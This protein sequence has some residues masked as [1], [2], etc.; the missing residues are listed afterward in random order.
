MEEGFRDTYHLTKCSR[1]A[2]LILII[3]E[4]GFRDTFKKNHKLLKKMVLILIIVEEGFRVALKGSVGNSYV[5]LNPYYSGRG[6]QR[7]F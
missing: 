4:E 2:V 1:L 7:Y 6:F 3:V 5:S